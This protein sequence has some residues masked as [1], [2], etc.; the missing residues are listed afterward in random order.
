M[1]GISTQSTR[2]AE[3]EH[4]TRRCLSGL[5]GWL[6]L[7]RFG[8]ARSTLTASTA[9][10]T[11]WEKVL[12]NIQA[13]KAVW[14]T[15]RIDLLDQ[16]AARAMAIAIGRHADALQLFEQPGGCA[17]A[18]LRRGDRVRGTTT[19]AITLPSGSN[20]Q[21]KLSEAPGLR[22]K[23]RLSRVM[24][25][26][27]TSTWATG[28]CGAH[29]RPRRLP[30]WPRAVGTLLL[31]AA[32]WQTAATASPAPSSFD[33]LPPPEDL[34]LLAEAERAWD[35]YMVGAQHPALACGLVCAAR[36]VVTGAHAVRQPAPSV[37]A[38][39]HPLRG[40]VLAGALR[41]SRR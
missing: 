7:L 37:E 16:R 33:W 31:P 1:R 6:L 30:S 32:E 15:Y 35:V 8:D 17:L 18:K 38:A 25:R 22:R 10:I 11:D 20:A 12:S 41:R 29:G 14:R 28:A 13:G 19:S 5:G 26:R 2:H 40:G 23:R 21:L 3:E 34:I 4:R 9:A 27:S 36:D 39:S 24:C